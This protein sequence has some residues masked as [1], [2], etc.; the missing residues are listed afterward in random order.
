MGTPASAAINGQEAL[1]N[2]LLAWQ[3]S[4][5]IMSS[6]RLDPPMAAEQL[7]KVKDR[8]LKH[9]AEL[10]SAAATIDAV[11][12][13]AQVAQVIHDQYECYFFNT[14][15]SNFM[16]R[17]DLQEA[18]PPE[19]VARHAELTRKVKERKQ[20][21][22]VVIDKLRTIQQEISILTTCTVPLE[23]YQSRS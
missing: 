3:E 21:L 16:I 11:D 1:Y 12:A 19:L 22:K 7:H 10:E 14:I 5:N 2:F 9:L 20:Q 18:P 6:Q 4:L 17:L 23:T 15:T 13:N 8:Y